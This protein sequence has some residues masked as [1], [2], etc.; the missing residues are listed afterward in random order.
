MYDFE[1]PVSNS[2]STLSPCMVLPVVWLFT[3]IGKEA[4]GENSVS[5]VIFSF[6]KYVVDMSLLSW[7]D[8]VSCSLL[9]MASY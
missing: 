4:S 6:P 7:K 5:L 8:L 1:A 3:F 2:K 9:L